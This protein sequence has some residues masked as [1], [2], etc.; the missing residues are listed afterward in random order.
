LEYLSLLAEA[1]IDLDCGDDN[2]ALRLLGHAFSLGRAQNIR[3]LLYWPRPA[4]MTRLCIKALE[5]GIE[6]KYVQSLVQEMRLVP[7]KAPLALENWPWQLKIYTLGSFNLVMDGKSAAFS[8]KAQQKP[9]AMLKA[10]IALGGRDV[11]EERL[12]DL[13]WPDADGAAAR[14]AFDTT[15]HRL[16]RLLVYDRAVVMSNGRITLNPLLCWVDAW[17]FD[18]ICGEVE[19]LQKRKAADK[20]QS[21]MIRLAEKAI[22]L[23]HGGFLPSDA[24]E[25]WAISK[26]EHLRGRFINIVDRLGGFLEE[27]G[28]WLGAAE[29]YHKGLET[30]DLAEELYRR[31]MVCHQ[32]LGKRAEALALYKRCRLTLAAVLGVAPCTETVA[33]F[34]EIA[35]Q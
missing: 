30:D 34:K 21:N 13:L 9:M 8:G 11:S 14:T 19:P 15:L 5:A 17:A 20:D 18:E 25:P 3:T 22:A 28:D 29:C 35:S 7:D 31:L 12:S 27:S 23:Y 1:H 4:K 10:L 24:G 16:R 26:R 2:G 6:V 32:K 33:L